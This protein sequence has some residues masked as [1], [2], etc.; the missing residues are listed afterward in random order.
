MANPSNAKYEEA[1]SKYD[2]LSDQYT[3]AAGYQQG[4]QA[5]QDNGTQFANTQI[6]QGNQAGK[7]TAAQAQRAGAEQ[8][9][10]YNKLANKAAK[11][12]AGEQARA[13]A[14]GAQSQA[15]TAARS[16]GMNKAQ[17]A[18]LGSQQNS[19]AYQNAY[20]NAYSQQLSNANA[21]MESARNANAQQMNNATNVYGQNMA[22]QQN[23]MMSSGNSAVSAAGTAM[24][25]GQQEGQN[26]YERTWGNWGAG[27]G[28]GS[29][30]LP[31][32][33]RLKHYQECSK[34]VVIKSPKAIAKLKYVKKEN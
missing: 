7:D 12:Q 19:N 21:N 17:A 34:K 28:L 16:A 20:G 32:D 24:G 14:A 33:E 27:L 2:A 4:V 5:A 30:L 22:N 23:A 1:K 31:S 25:A 8:G 29:M 9:L 15:T 26:E 10:E 13:A 3:G 6:T 11:E 18:M